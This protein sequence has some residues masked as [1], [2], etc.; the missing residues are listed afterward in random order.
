MAAFVFTH[1]VKRRI[2][3]TQTMAAIVFTL[4]GVVAMQLAAAT[5]HASWQ[6]AVLW[7][8]VA[9]GGS[10]AFFLAIRTGWSERFS[11]PSL[12]LWQM[13]YAVACCAGAYAIAGP[14]RGAVFPLVMVVLMFGMFSLPTSKVA[15]MSLYSVLLF[16]LTMVIMARR[17][18]S[19]FNPAV[20]AAHLLLVGTMMPAV[21]VLAAQLN[22]LR[23]RLRDQ[24]RDLAQALERIQYLATRDE[25]TGLANRR[26]IT[27]L[28]E[29]EHARS[30]RNGAPFCIAMI[31][32]DHFKR[33]N[34]EHGHAGGDE[35]LR[36][37]ASVGSREVRATDTLARWG[38]EEFLL[39]MPDTHLPPAHCGVER[40]R[41]KFADAA[42]EVGA[43]SFHVTLSA[44]VVQHQ[45]GDSIATTIGRADVAL[46]R[47]KQAGRNRVE[48]Q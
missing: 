6:A 24:R 20:E 27:E 44:G 33:I 23:T 13:A 14:M 5:G 4:P 36:Q 21:S 17:D 48:A 12:T 11:D 9:L 34:D 10:C 46:Y 22:R 2:R 41:H 32:L 28:M 16:G 29:R 43:S 35:T 25:L 31:D 7:A 45:P 8:V 15:G 26:Q 42:V 3:L 39:L 19:V 18:P 37:L 38:G 30:V 1:D 47:A 40:L